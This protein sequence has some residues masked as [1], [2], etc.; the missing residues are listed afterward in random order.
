M[1][2]CHGREFVNGNWFTVC[3][4]ELQGY[5]LIITRRKLFLSHTHILMTF[6]AWLLAGGHG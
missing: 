1:L 2:F 4:F 5:C 3:P 6:P